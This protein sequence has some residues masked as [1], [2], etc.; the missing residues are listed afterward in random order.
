MATINPATGSGTANP[1]AAASVGGDVVAFG[2]ATRPMI[3]V[4]NASGSSVT[5][6]LAGKVACNYGTLHSQ[7]QVCPAGQITD[8]IPLA[9]TID[10]ASATF[11][12]VSVTYSATTSVTVGALAS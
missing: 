9:Y 2:T 12:Q 6:T 3:Q 11:G 1:F 5:V 8:I 10:Q 4:N 7:T